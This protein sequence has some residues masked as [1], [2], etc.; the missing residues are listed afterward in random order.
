MKDQV[1]SFYNSP[2]GTIEVK[3]S[4]SGISSLI[5]VDEVNIVSKRDSVF[6]NC[7]TQLTEYFAGSRTQFDIEL[8]LQGTEFQKKVW[9]ELLRIEYG[10]TNT[11]SD[12][13]RR[14]GNLKSIRAVG[15]ANGSNPLS[16][17]VPCHRVI[18]SDGSLTGYAGGLWRKQWL[19][20]HEHKHAQLRLF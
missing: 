8:D 12:L 13:A 19:L 14:I 16:I 4:G 7:F 20:N 2:I 17:I 18:G 9:K 1:I 3:H 6:E 11:Y 10:R 5:F 15:K